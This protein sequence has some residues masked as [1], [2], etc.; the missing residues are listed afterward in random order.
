MN[1]LFA[2]IIDWGKVYN[3]RFNGVEEKLCNV[4]NSV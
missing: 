3:G 1:L 2:E 4:L